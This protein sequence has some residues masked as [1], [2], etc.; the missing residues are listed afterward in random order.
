MAARRDCPPPSPAA[1]TQALLH[2]NHRVK[3]ED[4]YAAEKAQR[5][6]PF[7]L[8]GAGA[9]PLGILLT[10][11]FNPGAFAD[12]HNYNAGPPLPPKDG[13]AASDSRKSPP[14]HASDDAFKDALQAINDHKAQSGRAAPPPPAPAG[15]AQ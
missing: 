2:P 9:G 5:D 6:A 14:Q 1:E 10:A 8:P 11:L 3:D 7:M 4:Y 15:A 13:D 12:K